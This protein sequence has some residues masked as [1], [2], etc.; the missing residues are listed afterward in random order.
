FVPSVPV[1]PPRTSFPQSRNFTTS[2]TISVPSYWSNASQKCVAFSGAVPSGKF[3]NP[4]PG[5]LP[6]LPF[7]F[8]F[9]VTTSGNGATTTFTISGQGFGTLPGIS[10]PT[11][12]N[13]PYLA[14][15]NNTQGWQAGNSLNGDQ[16]SLN[17]TA[18]S[19]RSITISGLNFS[20][21]KLVMKHNDKM[22][23]WV[24]N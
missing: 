2:G 16:V 17:V 10:V 1:L 8:P 23:V 7:N 3:G 6:L 14:I 5:R 18:W 21:G 20:N 19:D 9:G 12:S 13:L 11:S 15:Q 22:T 4:L 24:C